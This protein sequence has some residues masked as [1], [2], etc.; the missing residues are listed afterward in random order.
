MEVSGRCAHACLIDQPGS[1]FLHFSFLVLEEVNHDSFRALYYFSFLVVDVLLCL[2][3][4]AR[5]GQLQQRWA[6]PSIGL[7]RSC[8][9]QDL[10]RSVVPLPYLRSVALLCHDVGLWI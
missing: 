2:T 5:N 6:N 3:I 10:G 7:G 1:S 8:E 4:E 9:G